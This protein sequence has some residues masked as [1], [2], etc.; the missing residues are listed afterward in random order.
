MPCISCGYELKGLD[1]DGP[2]PEC[3]A[4]V[5]ESFYGEG[6]VHASPAY[7]ASLERGLWLVRVGIGLITIV[8]LGGIIAAIVLGMILPWT[9]PSWASEVLF[10]VT[11]MVCVG[12]Y[13]AGWWLVTTPDP[14]FSQHADTRSATCARWSA[15][16]LIATLVFFA[17]F[18]LVVPAVLALFGPA[19]S[20]L[21]IVQHGCGTV[22]LRVLARRAAN[23]R[24]M[25]H[26]KNA[27]VAVLAVCAGSVV[28]L[29]FNW[30]GVHASGGSLV[31]ALVGL[32]VAAVPVAILVAAIIAI[33]QQFSALGLLR[34]DLRRFL[35]HASKHG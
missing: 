13:V 35:F 15:V 32:F 9:L 10:V 16:A 31:R 4:P 27:V 20:I 1:A 7:L 23:R 30:F 21:L 14:R 3:G 6:L 34:D 17:V 24:A 18:S 29:A 12:A 11:T 19:L 22:H 33:V 25:S 26:T 2:C 8:L 28:Q 5:V